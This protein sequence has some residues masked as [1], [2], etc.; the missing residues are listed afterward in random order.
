M[1]DK[2]SLILY[3]VSTVTG[4]S[5]EDITSAKRSRE[6]VIARH[7]AIWFL[8]QKGLTFQKIGKLIGNRDHSTIV[9]AR[10]RI[11]NYLEIKDTLVVATYNAITEFLKKK[12]IISKYD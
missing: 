6:I 8:Y 4:I 2:E 7:M 5:Y 3:A 1:Q 10:D 12:E 9:C 11:K